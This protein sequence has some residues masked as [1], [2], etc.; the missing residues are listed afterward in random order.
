MPKLPTAAVFG[1]IG[2]RACA[3]PPDPGVAFINPNLYVP[4][5]S[6][7]NPLLCETAVQTCHADGEYKYNALV[8]APVS[9]HCDIRDR[10]D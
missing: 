8:F 7:S 2:G 4:S 3:R 6:F 9:S 5:T 1:S 10:Y